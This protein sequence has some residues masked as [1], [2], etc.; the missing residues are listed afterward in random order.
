MVCPKQIATNGWIVE[1]KDPNAKDEYGDAKVYDR[2]ED[3]PDDTAA[4]D[5]E[6][7]NAVEDGF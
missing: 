4:P 7:E 1:Y 6:V 3:L 2:P 5:E